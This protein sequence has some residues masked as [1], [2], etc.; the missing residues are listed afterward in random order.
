[1]ANKSVEP[2]TEAPLQIAEPEQPAHNSSKLT[3]PKHANQPIDDTAKWQR[4]SPIA[5]VYFGT[6][7]AK[8]LVSN[9]MYLLPAIVVGFSQIKEQPG[10]WLPVILSCIALFVVIALLKFRFYQYRLH[11]NTIEIRSGVLSKSHI[12]LPF[13]RVQNV[14][15]E[16]PIYYRLTGYACLQLDTAGSSKQ[17]AQVVALPLGFA[18]KLKQKILTQHAQS[19]SSPHTHAAEGNAA[20]V[21][22]SSAATTTQETTL[23]TRSVKD[24]VI[25]GISS[26][27]IWIFLG[28][29]APFFDNIF[30]YLSDV[31]SLFGINLAN[32]FSTETQS[33]WQIGIYGFMLFF[34]LMMVLAVFSIIGAVMS[35]YG[36]QLSKDGD[37]YIRRSGLFTK[38]EVTM[39]LSRLQMIVQRQDWLDRLIQ[40][41][42][43]KYEQVNA[44]IQNMA[45]SGVSSKIMVPSITPSESQALID[46]VYPD[47]QLSKIRYM[48]VNARYLVRPIMLYALPL[49]IAGIA[50]FVLQQVMWLSTG[51]II[52]SILSVAGAIQTWKRWGFA[53]DDNY[54]YVR[55]GMIGVDY[56]CVPIYKIQQ[57]AYKQSRF[58]KPHQL[59]TVQLVLASGSVSIP[60]IA[61]AQAYSLIDRSLYQVEQSK[62]S[63]M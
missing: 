36:Y 31:F 24:L 8:M 53:M 54:I 26:N 11:Q 44:N 25:H 40:R 59:A 52:L 3:A 57:T 60:F 41:V 5:I 18:E 14:K 45:E 47:N 35:F 56:Y 15:L 13:E 34:M 2:L 58:M 4:L 16:Q 49:F 33:W 27:R 10:L 46:N 9:F 21:P 22:E 38:H 37:K 7:M 51:L 50:S 39:R 19:A 12:N 61:E 17:E 32:L 1:M 62:R 23:I 6:R 55:K 29:M 63:W 28:V 43:L 42:N 20:P 30:T 48:A